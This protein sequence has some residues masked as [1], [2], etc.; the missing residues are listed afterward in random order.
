M[1]QIQV[2]ACC[3]HR[4]LDYAVPLGAEAHTQ[5]VNTCQHNLKGLGAM[6]LQ[7]LGG[8]SGKNGSPCVYE[9]DGDYIWQGY[10]VDDP[11]LLEQLKIP[12]G[13][14]VVRVPKAVVQFLPKDEPHGVAD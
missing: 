4:N 3:R 10:P 2:D 6:A 12:E 5:N 11:D 13:E 9:L 14:I 7:F 8:P 1:S